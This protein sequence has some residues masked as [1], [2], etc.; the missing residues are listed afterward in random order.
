MQVRKKFLKRFRLSIFYI[1]PSLILIIMGLNNSADPS[2]NVILNYDFFRSYIFFS[3]ICVGYFFWSFIYFLQE[4]IF[5][6]EYL[7]ITIRGDGDNP[8]KLEE[9]AAKIQFKF[10]KLFLS[11]IFALGFASIV[12][13]KMTL[14]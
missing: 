1:F 9:Q 6:K 12:A 13:N 10:Y 2:Y 11:M 5:G 3:L 7:R 8:N 4:I 14:F